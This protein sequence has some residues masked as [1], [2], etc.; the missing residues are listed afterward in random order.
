MFSKKTI[1]NVDFKDQKVLVRCDFNVKIQDGVITDETR[2]QG[3]LPTIKYLIDGGAKI[4]LC[5]H[6]GKPKGKYDPEL[7]LKPVADRLS[8]ILGQKIYFKSDGQVITQEIKDTIDQLEPGEIALLDN[9]R[10][11][12]EETENGESF[13]KELASLAE[14]FVNDAFGTVHRAHAS[15]EGVTHFMKDSVSGFLIEKEL[16]F[17][18][19]AIEKPQRPFI[20]I[21]GGAKISDK[22]KVIDELIG[23]VDGLIIGGGMAYTF[24]KAQG[25]EIG[26]SMLEEDKLDYA[27]EMIK[28]AKRMG[29]TLM[30]PVDHCVSENFADNPAVI[31][32]GQNIPEETMGLDIGPKTIERFVNTLK[33]AKTVLWNGPM[34][35]FEFE[36]YNKGT[37]ALAK[38]MS[39]LDAVTIVGGG[40]S[41]AAV[42]QLGYKDQ[43]THISTGG[44]ASLKFLEGSKLPGIE[45]L[46]N[47]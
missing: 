33:N 19:Q 45:A 7:T 23:K 13:S 25:Y 17:L 32:E 34:G 18:G 46:D 43:M 47:L 11:R 20:A 16:E 36:N 3:A 1:L 12:I 31:T 42:A 37:L 38:C 44:G 2:I 27:L 5:S 41:A 40:D 35:V 21:L 28:K 24:L 9:T 30:L 14:I 39:T 22:I 26:N 4:I 8:E 6:R 29:V 15:T 10:F